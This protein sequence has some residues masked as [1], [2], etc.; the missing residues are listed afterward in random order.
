[1]KRRTYVAALVLAVP[2]WMSAQT[3]NLTD[4]VLRRMWALGMDSSQTYPLAQA[5]LDSIGPRLT[6]SPGQ[7]AGIEWLLSRYRMWGISARKEQ[8][9]SVKGWQRGP[10]H[11]DLLAPRVRTL[12]ALMMI[13]SPGTG[14][15]W[16]EGDVVAP[17]TDATQI[18]AWLQTV[19]GKFVLLTPPEITC[20]PDIDWE[21]WALPASIEKL[22]AQREESRAAWM[23]RIPQDF[24]DRAEAA[25]AAGVLLGNWAHGWGVEVME[26]LTGRKQI[27]SIDLSCEDYGLLARLAEH[28]QSPRIRVYADAAAL[29]RVPVYNTV[30]E[31]KGS[32]KPNEYVMLS[33]H[34][35]SWDA[36]SGTTDNGTGTVIM[37]EA[38]RILKAAYPHP[39]RT[40]LVGHWSGEEQGLRGSSAFVQAHPDIIAGLHVLFNND[41]GTRRTGFISGEGVA[42][43]GAYFTRWLAQ[44]PDV[45]TKEIKRVFPDKQNFTATDHM[46]FLSAGV[47]AF[48][49][50][51]VPANV[52]PSYGRYTWHTNRD[53]FDKLSFDDLKMTATLTAMLVYLASEDAVKFPRS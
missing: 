33:A 38:M 23:R 47:P 36:S 35:D 7:R 3:P 13:G 4:P 1:M 28:R 18:D 52:G 53:T 17:P 9:D 19:K 12:E 25:G 26:Q 41:A 50:E 31:I 44:I 45:L 24:A 46:S 43:S 48:N 10:T 15:R 5:L 11:V 8:Y 16:V 20:R 22:K 42:S 29:G 30:A 27:P 2:L 51:S 14:G 49:L 39:K 21:H 34:F 37:L 6:G 32:E 40:I